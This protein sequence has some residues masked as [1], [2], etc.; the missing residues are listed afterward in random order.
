MFRGF[1]C[2]TLTSLTKVYFNEFVANALRNNIII[3][4]FTYKV[5]EAVKIPKTLI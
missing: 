4:I 2:E 5:M 1:G 3:M